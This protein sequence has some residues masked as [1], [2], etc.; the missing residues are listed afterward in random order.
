MIENDDYTKS[1][2]ERWERG[3]I[4]LSV[5]AGLG[6]PAAQLGLA[7]HRVTGNRAQEVRQLVTSEHV[8][9]RVPI[10]TIR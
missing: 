7:E 3:G 9:E 6:R 2:L 5:H 8:L 4:E 10:A 1:P